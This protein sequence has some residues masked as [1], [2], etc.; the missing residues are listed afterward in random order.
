M[1]YRK[2]FVTNSSSSSY[3][4][5][6]CGH[7]DSGWD[8]SL[9]EVGMIECVNEHIICDEHML[10]FETDLDRK[11]MIE[12]IINAGY[13]NGEILDSF[14]DDDLKEKYFRDVVLDYGY[15]AP[16]EVCPI[17]QF[18][19]YSERDLANYLERTYRV[20]REFVLKQVKKINSRRKK[21]YDGEYIT[22]VCKRFNLDP[23]EIV[24]GWKSQ[25]ATYKDLK[26][27]IIGKTENT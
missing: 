1:K 25:F 7:T 18:I 11:A 3:I 15:G 2:D 19:D 4:C 12:A 26:N 21:L 17:C 23:T 8:I 22:H 14:D 24:A 20:P 9:P 5:E 27:F 6:I 13:E 10:P 16:E